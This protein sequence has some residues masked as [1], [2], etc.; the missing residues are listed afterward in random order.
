MQTGRHINVAVLLA[1]YNGSQY[2][3]QQV[4]SLKHN[5]IPFTLHWLD[6]HSTDNTRE[7]VRAAAQYAG[8]KIS[9]WHQPEH[10]GVPGAF[11]QLLEC[12]EADIYLFCDQDDIWQPGKIDAAVADLLDDMQLPVLCCTD[13][14]MFRESDPDDFYRFLDLLGADAEAALQESRA[15]LPVIGCG[16][17]QGFTRPLRDIYMSHK[18]IARRYA[19]MHDLWMYAIAFASGTVRLLPNAPTTLYR[20]HTLNVSGDFL[21]WRG[22]GVF[23]VTIPWQ[24]LPHIRRRL[25]RNAQGFILASRTMPPS[26]ALQRILEIAH[27]VAALERRHSMTEVFRLAHRGIL[28]PNIRLAGGI[29]A[30]CLWSDARI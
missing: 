24:Q 16:H 2:V 4:I 19:V 25:S 18:A 29:M 8:I 12:I 28:W 20:W 5:T 27:L 22:R 26:S 9:E 30:N 10:Q 21:R 13:P 23:R 14:L 11:F 15:F 17:T 6:D 7:A 1:T 3:T